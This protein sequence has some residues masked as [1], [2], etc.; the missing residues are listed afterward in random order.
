MSEGSFQ[1]E[2][3]NE[4]AQRNE[5]LKKRSYRTFAPGDALEKKGLSGQIYQEVHLVMINILCVIMCCI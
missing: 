1:V 4:L 5:R 2:H 3:N